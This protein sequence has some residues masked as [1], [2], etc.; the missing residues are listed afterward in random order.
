MVCF[1]LFKKQL[2]DIS[3]PEDATYGYAV[4]F[5]G[6]FLGKLRFLYEYYGIEFP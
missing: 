5:E 6:A 3:I 1:S 4:Y 2:E